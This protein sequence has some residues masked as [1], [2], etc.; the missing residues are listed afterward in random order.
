MTSATLENAKTA[1][2]N[3][4]TLADCEQG[5]GEPVVFVHGGLGDLRI[6]QPQLPAVGSAYRA[7]TYSRRFARPNEEISP[8]AEDPWLAHVDDL[9]AFVRELGAAP[10]HQSALYYSVIA[11]LPPPKSLFGVSPLVQVLPS[12]KICLIPSWLWMYGLL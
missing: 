8:G 12:S 4:T 1:K 7:I 6:W 9:A 5:E 3:G 10:A 2:V 11:G